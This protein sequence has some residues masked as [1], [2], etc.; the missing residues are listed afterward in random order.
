MNQYAYRS[1]A[2]PTPQYVLDRDL[3]EREYF[4]THMARFDWN[5]TQAAKFFGMSRTV[6]SHKLTKLMIPRG[7]YKSQ[8]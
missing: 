3:W 4:A 1:G 7:K 5:V 8:L 6:L 2:A